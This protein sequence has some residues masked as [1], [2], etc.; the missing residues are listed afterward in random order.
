LIRL[1]FTDGPEFRLFGDG[2]GLAFA[3]RCKQAQASGDQQ[4]G[5]REAMGRIQH[6]RDAWKLLNGQSLERTASRDGLGR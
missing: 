5:K 4:G 2:F 3:A 1:T 6:G